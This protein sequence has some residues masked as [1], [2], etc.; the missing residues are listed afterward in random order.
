MG[1]YRKYG[2]FMVFNVGSQ[3][4]YIFHVLHHGHSS[5]W[6]ISETINSFEKPIVLSAQE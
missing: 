3:P 4:V 1:A 2:F 6:K 5:S